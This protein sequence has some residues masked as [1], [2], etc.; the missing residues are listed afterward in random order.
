VDKSRVMLAG[1][2]WEIQ[3]RNRSVEWSSVRHLYVRST[4]P[5]QFP[6]V[7]GL[8]P[9]ESCSP[10]NLPILEPVYLGTEH[11][12]IISEDCCPASICY[13]GMPDTVDVTIRHV[14]GHLS[15]V[16]LGL[17]HVSREKLA[18]AGRGIL[19]GMRQDG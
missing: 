2:K 16:N 9:Q 7:R 5:K 4:T 10:L 17:E 18:Q 8:Q 12:V 6:L 11:A 1:P 3:I 13:V 15:G 19:S 14:S